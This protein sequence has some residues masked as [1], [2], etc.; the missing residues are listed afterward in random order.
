MRRHGGI[1]A[2]IG[3]MAGS[4]LLAGCSVLGVSPGSA[5]DSSR[6]VSDQ[7]APLTTQVR[8]AAGGAVAPA[9]TQAD[10]PS[11]VFVLM[12]DFSMDLLQTMKGARRLARTGASYPHSFVVDSLCCVSR[13]SIFTGQYPHQTGVRTNTAAGAGAD[14]PM[15]GWEAFDTYGNAERSFNTRLQGAGY[16]TGFVGKYLNEYEYVPGRKPVPPVPPGWSQFN[17]VFGSAYDG[18]DFHSTTISGG[19]LQLRAHPAPPLGSTTE[20]L[21]DAYAG[22]IIEDYA[23]DFIRAH[24]DDRAPY[25]LEVA[26][27]A[28]HS[29]TTAEGAYPG[30]PLFPPAFRDRPGGT[31]AAGNCGMPCRRLTVDDLP[32]YADDSSD[33]RPRRRNGSPATAWNTQA[34]RL[35]TSA[36]VTSL[37]T[38]AQMAQSVDRTLRKIIKAV[39]DDTYVVLTSDNGFHLGQLG[40]GRGKGTA[41]DTDVR[42]PLLIAGPGVTPGAR[43][44]MVNNI[45]LAPT[46]EDL[47]GV[48]S[49]RY[50]SGSS[51]VPS[52][53]SPAKAER[54]FVFFEH[55]SP[56]SSDDPDQAFTGDELSRIPS[57]VA[58][59][60]R[61]GLLIRYDLDPTPASVERGYEFYS[62]AKR[63]WERKNT[64]AAPRN[65]AEVEVLMGKLKAFDRCARATRGAAV[66]PACHDLTR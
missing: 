24:R 58:V 20:A 60:S 1:A 63:P 18:W 51:L 50:R 29:R 10:R 54:N 26:P 4:A 30:D 43:A 52:L 19:Q 46:F 61:T 64:F 55:T 36:Y 31:N 49:P 22:E 5:A 45:D 35:P 11:I 66:S 40:L 3:L 17:V 39:G 32:G 8:P 6:P 47:A 62:Y 27:Y 33:N 7:S 21:D 56:R 2:L 41:Y 12:D 9:I 23:L 25:F 16:T 53:R 37:R 34:S 65:Q 15:G 44:E 42:V 59:R 38:R 13:S 48:A 28:T 14:G 57:Y